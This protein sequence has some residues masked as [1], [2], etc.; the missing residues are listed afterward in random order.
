MKEGQRRGIARPGARIGV[1]WAP[2]QHP[3]VSAPAV[4]PRLNSISPSA[5]RVTRP[6]EAQ[7]WRRNPWLSCAVVHLQC[8]QRG[9]CQSGAQSGC[10]ARLQQASIS[11]RI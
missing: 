8:V 7:R 10:E 9:Q 1:C 11:Q 3:V 2:E 6:F 4:V 5:L